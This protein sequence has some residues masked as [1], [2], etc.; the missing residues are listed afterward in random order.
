M[1]ISDRMVLVVARESADLPRLAGSESPMKNPC[2]SIGRM[3][4]AEVLEGGG[5]AQIPVRDIKLAID[6][7]DGVRAVLDSFDLFDS[8]SR[9][10]LLSF[11]LKRAGA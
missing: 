9:E 7:I 1:N 10:P 2:G 8:A 5:S 4:A 3:I 6:N 11:L